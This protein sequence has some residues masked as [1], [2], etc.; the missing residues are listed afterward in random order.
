MTSDTLNDWCG[1]PEY[2]APE[3]VKRQGY[4]LKA[5]MWSVGVIMYIMLAGIPPFKDGNRLRLY[6]KISKGEYSFPDEN[7]KCVSE[8]AK[9]L[10][11]R[12]L[13]V[14]PAA[15]LDCTG[16]LAHPWLSEATPSRAL[17]APMSKVAVGFNENLKKFNTIRRFQN[18]GKQLMNCQRFVNYHKEETAA[19]EYA[20]KA[21][22]QNR[23]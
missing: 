18:T 4:G 5:D 9:D 20:R 2:Q 6:S 12:L 1:T 21:V 22:I 11:K 19:D 17:P 13:C 3:V 23:I 7:W 15:R 14:D 16:T 8:E 10:I